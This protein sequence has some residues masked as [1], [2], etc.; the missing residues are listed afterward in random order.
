MRRKYQLVPAPIDF[1]ES[2]MVLSHVAPASG[3]N[4]HSP[5]VVMIRQSQEVTAEIN[6]DFD[7][8]QIDYAQARATYFTSIQNQAS[9]SPA[10]TYAFVGYTTQRVSLLAQQLLSIVPQVKHG[11]AGGTRALKQ[12]VAAKI[13]GPRQQ[14]PP[15]SLAQSLLA[16][17]PQPGT[18]A[19]TSSLYTLSQDNAI[20]SAQVA[21]LN[22]MVKH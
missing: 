4:L 2:R 18:T 19:P 7:L 8:F 11:P 10:T 3:A 14:M 13:I 1:L 22:G 16:T 5:P 17:I 15:G 21:I 20:A 12:L 6:Q 9:P